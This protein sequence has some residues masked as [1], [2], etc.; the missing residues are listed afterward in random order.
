[1]HGILRGV[2][3]CEVLQSDESH[4]VVSVPNIQVLHNVVNIYKQRSGTSYSQ[5]KKPKLFGERSTSH[6]SIYETNQKIIIREHD[7][8]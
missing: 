5:Y 4:T 8:K 1:M 3:N 7:H 6:N 2:P